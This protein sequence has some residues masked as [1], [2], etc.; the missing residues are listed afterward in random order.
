M[1]KNDHDDEPT[2]VPVEQPRPRR[3]DSAVTLSIRSLVMGG[4]AAA[5]IAA[6]IAALVVFV[7]R[8]VSARNKLEALETSQAER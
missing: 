5:L 7:V 6:L 2:A 3:G 8:D 4:V 1:T